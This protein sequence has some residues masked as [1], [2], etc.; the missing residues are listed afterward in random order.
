M[1]IPFLFEL[2]TLLDWIITDTTLTFIHWLKLEDIYANLF[3][4]KCKREKEK[5]INYYEKQSKLEKIGLGLT[6]F[7]GCFFIF[8]Y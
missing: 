5:K 6:V 8:F 4:V 1:A 7:C 3:L 2:R